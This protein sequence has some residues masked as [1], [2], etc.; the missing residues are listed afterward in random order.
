MAPVLQVF[1]TG[2]RPLRN[3]RDL[4]RADKKKA[5]AFGHALIRRGVF[6]TPGGKLYLSLAHAEIRTST[7]SFNSRRRCRRWGD[8]WR[9]ARTGVMTCFSVNARPLTVAP[10]AWTRGLW[11][12]EWWFFLDSRFRLRIISRTCESTRGNQAPCT[13]WEEGVVP[14]NPKVFRVFLSSSFGDFKDERN[15]LQ[16]HVFPTIS[17]RC[18]QQGGRFQAVDLRWGVSEEA[19]HDRRT[20]AICFKEIESCQ[21]F[22]QP[23]FIALLGQRYGW[24][25]LPQSIS[26]AEFDELVAASSEDN[27]LRLE[28][29][30]QRDDNNVT[31]V[32]ALLPRSGQIIASGRWKREEDLIQEAF[33]DAIEKTLPPDDPRRVKYETSATHHEIL[34]AQRRGG[35][36]N[37]Y[38]RSIE[39]ISAGA[40]AAIY[41]DLAGDGRPQTAAQAKIQRLRNEMQQRLPADRCYHYSLPSPMPWE[42]H[43]PMPGWLK[44]FCDRVEADLWNQIEAGLREGITTTVVLPEWR[45]AAERATNF[46]GRSEELQHIESYV[47]GQR[48]STLFVSGPSGIGKTALLSKWAID[49]PK[50]PSHRILL[51]YCGVTPGANLVRDLL[52]GLCREI[53]LEFHFEMLKREELKH[54]DV[55]EQRNKQR[56]IEERYAIPEDVKELPWTFSRFLGMVP[57]DCR[58]TI[59]L[60]ALDQLSP[61]DDAWTLDWL[62]RELPSHVKLLASVLD[63]EEIGNEC[64][65]SA[66]AHFPS[67]SIVRV[68]DL[69]AN[70]GEGIF[71]RWLRAES[72][73]RTLTREQWAAILSGFSRCPRTAVFSRRQASGDWQPFGPHRHLERT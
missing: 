68:G 1:F 39:N 62:P 22:P 71:N 73:P 61:D 47:Q 11:T 53:E 20:M 25:P 70:L 19:S 36:S 63:D 64:A 45:F 26:I 16:R 4:T 8:T 5:V 67:D 27:R 43:Q 57:K 33:Q 17:E 30:Y 3:Y 15:A 24:R 12:W 58:L 21:K 32:Y 28:R 37:C 50:K 51:R 29:W 38:L 10:L 41:L 9:G 72:E 2:Q 65:R 54:A 44:S 46:D 52:S 55:G 40:E 18:L 66:Q 59:V 60:D 49:A 48:N 6:S 7:E 56:E 13:V 69:T 14:A 23:N 34:A 31:P 35:I 42:P